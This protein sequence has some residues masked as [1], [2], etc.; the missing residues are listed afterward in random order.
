M[1]QF[2]EGRS[3]NS[4]L[5]PDPFM[6]KPPTNQINHMEFELDSSEE[7]NS[8]TLPPLRFTTPT[9]PNTRPIEVSSDPLGHLS[10]SISQFANTAETHRFQKRKS[11]PTKAQ[12]LLRIFFTDNLPSNIGNLPTTAREAILQARDLII[13]AYSKTTREEQSKLLDLLEIFREFT[14]SGKITKI[15]NIIASQI[16]NLETVTRKIESKTRN[17]V[18]NPKTNQSTGQSFAKVANS[19]NIDNSKPQE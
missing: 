13:I 11:P 1:N 10:P 9:E 2:S 5:F 8:P 6:P 16:A 18:N 17:L 15:S 12:Q 7:L 19:T 14:E 3:K 4:D